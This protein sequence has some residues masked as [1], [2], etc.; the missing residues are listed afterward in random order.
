MKKE[1]KIGW[2]GTGIMGTAM[3]SNLLK[4]GFS[5]NAYNRTTE[6]TKELESKGAKVLLSPSAL[7]DAS[8]IIFLMLTN[9]KACESV[10]TEKEG[11]LDGYIGEGKV[12]VNCSTIS[13]AISVKLGNLAKENGFQ[14]LDGPVSGS[15]GAAR[16]GSL[17]FL[18]GGDKDIFE[19]IT[20]ILDAMGKKNYYLGAVSQGNKA[21]LAINYLVAIDYLAI[22]ETIHFAESMNVHPDDMMDIINNSG[23][24]NVTSRIK[25]DPIVTGDYS[26]IAF[27]LDNMLKDLKLAKDAGNN[28][29]LSN[30]VLDTYLD[31]SKAGYGNKDVM[32]VLTYLRKDYKPS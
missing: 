1:S 19:R 10:F 20:P 9:D 17:L 14:Y 30:T 3:A 16:E 21:K 23:V 26:N 24:G 4:N 29:P 32:E 6:K 18:V 31:A 13:P 5:V 12:I 25:T 28:V 7:R 15:A 27:A 11:L 2:I 22:G 8:D